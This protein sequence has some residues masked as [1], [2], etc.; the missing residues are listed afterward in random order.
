MDGW[1]WMGST[2]INHYTPPSLVSNQSILRK[3]YIP[4]CA[5]ADKD[6]GP[7]VAHT[8]QGNTHALPPTG[9]QHSHQLHTQAAPP[10]QTTAGL[11][12]PQHS[13]AAPIGSGVVGMR[14][15]VESNTEDDEGGMDED[16]GDDPMLDAMDGRIGGS[17]LP[18]TLDM[19]STMGAVVP[20]DADD[21]VVKVNQ[22]AVHFY[23]GL[24]REATALEAQVAWGTEHS[25]AIWNVAQGAFQF[26]RH[27]NL[28]GVENLKKIGKFVGTKNEGSAS[29]RTLAMEP[30]PL[31]DGVNYGFTISLIN[32]GRQKRSN[33]SNPATDMQT[34]RMMVELLVE[35]KMTQKN[36]SLT[37]GIARCYETMLGCCKTKEEMGMLG[38]ILRN[39][40]RATKSSLSY[41]RPTGK[42][43][44]YSEL[45]RR[46]ARALD[47]DTRTLE[48]G[49]VNSLNLSID[50]RSSL[51]EFLTKDSTWSDKSQQINQICK[52]AWAMLS[53]ETKEEF[54]DIGTKK[55]KREPDSMEDKVQVISDF[56]KTINDSGDLQML[57]VVERPGQCPERFG[58]V[59]NHVCGYFSAPFV[60]SNPNQNQ[61][62]TLQ[63]VSPHTHTHVHSTINANNNSVVSSVGVHPQNLMIAD[64][65]TNALA[66]PGAGTSNVHSHAHPHTQSH[67]HSQ[68]HAHAHGHTHPHTTQTGMSTSGIAALDA[69]TLNAAGYG[70]SVGESTSVGSDNEMMDGTGAKGGVK[71]S[72]ENLRVAVGNK[73]NAMYFSITDE[74]SIPW[75]RFKKIGCPFV[76]TDRVS[77]HHYGEFDNWARGVKGHYNVKDLK[78]LME[79]L[80]RPETTFKPNI[81]SEYVSRFEAL[82]AEQQKFVTN[83]ISSNREE[84][85]VIY[86]TG[87]AGTGKTYVATLASEIYRSI[88]GEGA[89]VTTGTYLVSAQKYVNG[90]TIQTALG[91]R[92]NEAD[93][94]HLQNYSKKEAK[95][96]FS[97]TRMLVIDSMGSVSGN[98]LD[99]LDAL[100]RRVYEETSHDLPFGGLRVCLVGDCLQKLRENVD[101]GT[102]VVEDI[103]EGGLF[104][105]SRIFRQLEANDLIRF[106]YL[107]EMRRFQDAAF[108]AYL[109]RLRR[110]EWLGDVRTYFKSL[111]CHIDSQEQPPIEIF[112]NEPICQMR[113]QELLR[114][115]EDEC[116]P[117]IIMNNNSPETEGFEGDGANQAML[118]ATIQRSL[119]D[120]SHYRWRPVQ[121]VFKGCRVRVYM[122]VHAGDTTIPAGSFGTVV[123]M[124]DSIPYV[125][126][127]AM[128]ESVL[129]VPVYEQK[130]YHYIKN[131][132][133]VWRSIVPLVQAHYMTTNS[134]KGKEFDSSVIVHVDS[135]F[136]AEHLYSAFAMT[137]SPNKLDVRGGD[138]I[139][140]LSTSLQS[141][142]EFDLRAEEKAGKFS[143]R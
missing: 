100:L 82:N 110:G 107:T 81:P 74:K 67:A 25:K 50:Q 132:G 15:D 78:N 36:K 89:V 68:G 73:L 28:F 94:D 69:T 43:S 122:N 20:V 115:K 141:L 138:A 55:R 92:D 84:K 83:F 99:Q 33:T 134:A 135:G 102:D 104:F 7:P 21:D 90:M 52:T 108:I 133:E 131:M 125:L 124:R 113:F 19:N 121:Q 58:Q 91:A 65:N 27:N 105:Q 48:D 59:S 129:A 126:F 49:F 6:L 10:P 39:H 85:T 116:F 46:V 66:A 128:G 38:R 5:M 1:G 40:A 71:I 18:Y 123:D 70:V 76:L 56:V 41:S 60:T 9:Q 22:T 37:P 4:L 23:C 93:L 17:V 87:V 117:P 32:R 54:V 136:T 127:D 143:L 120:D 97:K 26:K 139:L 118:A 142:V 35:V 95:N 2:P 111:H 77:G 130:E 96:R 53:P 119:L 47:A 80:E 62:Q 112:N 51:N 30:Y 44:G 88:Y 114:V 79:V 109:K 14:E 75:N 86:L 101:N 11:L 31:S 34:Q 29:T 140:P 72:K 13:L 137:T 3:V 45:M 64:A 12:P 24:D 8:L 61:Q 16:G 103:P 57:A 63:G 98:F 106:F 42:Y